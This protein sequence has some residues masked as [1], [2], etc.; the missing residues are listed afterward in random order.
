MLSKSEASD[1]SKDCDISHV[2]SVLLKSFRFL[3]AHNGG[4]KMDV[5]IKLI[6]HGRKEVT[7]TCGKVYRFVINPEE[8]TVENNCN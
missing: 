1:P 2:E 7:V 4:G 6:K 3:M 8:I 5:N